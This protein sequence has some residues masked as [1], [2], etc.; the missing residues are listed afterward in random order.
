M[1]M[2]TMLVMFFR[3]ILGIDDSTFGDG[4]DLHNST[5]NGQINSTA[6]NST[7]VRTPY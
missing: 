7:T 5:Q 1:M 6:S 3:L 4:I 2:T